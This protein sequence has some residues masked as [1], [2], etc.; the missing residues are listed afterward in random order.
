M[1]ANFQRDIQVVETLWGGYRGSGRTGGAS[2]DFVCVCF[3]V[4]G[5][6]CG[7]IQKPSLKVKS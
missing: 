5:C 2:E 1:V 7:V 4:A 6:W 3:L